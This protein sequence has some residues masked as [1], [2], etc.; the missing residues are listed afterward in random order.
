MLEATS[1]L[2]AL[3]RAIAAVPD[4]LADIAAHCIDRANS[5]ASHNTYV[6]FSPQALLEE[7][8]LLARSVPNPRF[9]PPLYGIPI[10]LKD[11]FD[12]AGT[13]TTCGSRFYADTTPPARLDS[14]MA[15]A[16][17]NAGALITGKTH[18]HPLAYGITGQNAE[19]GDCLQ[20]RD[21]TLL[22]GGSSSG[23]AA[24]VQEDSALA[25]I[26]TD[27]G[28]SIRVPAA[29]CGLTGYRA[30]HS[31]AYGPGPWRQSP[32][33]LWQGAAHLAP[34]FDTPGFLLRDPR[35]LAPIAKAVF[36]VPLAAL[37]TPPRIGY[38]DE[39]FLDDA[40]PAVLTAY[41]SWRR[42]L[43]PLAAFL[44]PF[45][46][47]SRWAESREIFAGIQ[48][49]EAA[50]QHTGHFHHFEPAIAS[51]LRTGAS[52]SRAEI[53][54]FHRRLKHFRAYMDYL[55]Q[56]FD[57][58]ILPAAPVHELKAAEDQSEI[59]GRILRYTTPFS[60]AG[61]P[62]VSLPGEILGAPNGTG[63]QLAAAPGRDGTLLA[64]AAQIGQSLTAATE[65]SPEQRAIH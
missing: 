33:G 26:G 40:T 10:S 45:N 57:V 44:E 19:Y 23:A 30:S 65:D 13:V 60:L 54:E 8:S 16:L 18:L 51:R 41:R 58:I 14:A 52:F 42:H 37:P 25:A 48:A 1:P 36:G 61:S 29:L 27:T 28:G 56:H 53:D 21:A 39:A 7:A 22:T 50:I 64:F 62:V 15:N 49:A 9:R 47:T 17:R 31:L 12:L 35:D 59:R 11:C 32:E 20:P 55:H 4:A 3:R 63:I 5:N 6:H 2:A 38:V 24:S 34:T 43:I 46:P